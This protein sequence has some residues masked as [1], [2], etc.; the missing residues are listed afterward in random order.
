MPDKKCVLVLIESSRSY[1]RGCLAGIASYVRAHPFWRVMH[2]ERSLGK[3]MRSPLKRWQAD[4]VIARV[5]TLQMARSVNRLKL[6]TVHMRSMQCALH[7]GLLETDHEACAR[8]AAEHF[9][10]NRHRHFAFCGYPGVSFSDQRCT[11]FIEHVGIHGYSVAVFDAAGDDSEVDDVIARESRGELPDRRLVAWLKSLP[12]PLALFACNDIR[13]REALAACT[14]AGFRVPEDVSVLGVDNDE[15][16]CDLSTPPLSS[17]QTDTKR[18]GYEGAAILG[19]M[20]AGE[21]APKDTILIP[22]KGVH[23]RQ[24]TDTFALT[25]QN[26]VAALSYIWECA[27]DG[28]TVQDVANHVALSRA[29]LDRRFRSFLGHSP[30]KEIDRIR[31]NRAKQLLVE[32]EY[33]ISAVA[34]MTGYEMAPQ[35]VTAFRRLTG[36]TPGEYRL[37]TAREKS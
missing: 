21:P 26:I 25:D 34:T 9:I 23:V 22:P 35:F 29:T 13:G 2:L 3:G 10:R 30:K 7:G 11:S 8:L 1:N 37:S 36:M 32:T 19:R 27:C 31:V 16:I 15:V 12:K 24:S 14:Q 4:G 33:K 28:I 18:I 6:P 5:E 20:M 17:I